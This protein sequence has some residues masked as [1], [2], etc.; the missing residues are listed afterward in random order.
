MNRRAA[1]GTRAGLRVIDG[2]P[3]E[4]TLY[5]RAFEKLAGLAVHGSAA[6]ELITAAI[7]ALG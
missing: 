6:R 4:I 1:E 5:V 7:D 3:S 2:A